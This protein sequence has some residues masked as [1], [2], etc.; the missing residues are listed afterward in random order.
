MAEIKTNSLINVDVRKFSVENRETTVASKYAMGFS[1]LKTERIK[2]VFE[3]GCSSN[4]RRRCCAIHRSFSRVTATKAAKRAT[5]PKK[6][7]SGTSTSTL[8]PPTLNSFMIRA[9]PFTSHLSRRR[10]ISVK[11][12]TAW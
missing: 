7:S 4:G 11:S 10:P 2:P 12:P 8:K 1:R 9:R 5:V 6:N 3:I